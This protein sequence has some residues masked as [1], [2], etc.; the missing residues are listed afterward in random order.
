[1]DSGFDPNKFLKWN[2]VGNV[3]AGLM[4]KKLN[5]D[6]SRRLLALLV[7]LIV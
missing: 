7:F 5:R 6:L 3:S 1:M 2:L 4:S